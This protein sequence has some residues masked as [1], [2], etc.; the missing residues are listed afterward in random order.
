MIDFSGISTLLFDIDNTL[1]IFNEKDFINIYAKGIHKYFESEFESP[2]EFMEIF[3]KSTGKM[4]ENEPDGVSNLTK[5][6]LDFEKKTKLPHSDIINRLLEFYQNDFDQ[7][8]LA[9]KVDP[10]AMKL[11]KLA[12]KHFTIVAATNPLFP[13]IANEIRLSWGSI[14]SKSINWNEITSADHYKYTKP[15]QEYYIELLEKIKKK[16]EE[17]M[18]IGDDKVNDMVAG[19][20]GIKTYNVTHPDRKFTKILKTKLDNENP[21]IPVDYAGSLEV[22]YESLI[23]FLDK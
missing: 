19:K 8:K 9:I 16:P 5:F 11:L 4:F 22:F 14:N 20:L 13:A 12:E 3:L 6:A 1:I 21:D 2:E 23:Q 17:C 15:N 18:M 7:I 10:I